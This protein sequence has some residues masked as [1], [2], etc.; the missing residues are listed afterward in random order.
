MIFRKTRGDFPA[1]KYTSRLAAKTMKREEVNAAYSFDERWVVC[2]RKII[3]AA[4][5][6]IAQ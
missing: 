4:E 5:K 6:V 2:S 3:I 1:A